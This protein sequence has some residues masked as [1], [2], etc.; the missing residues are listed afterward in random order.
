MEEEIVE[1]MKN[2]YDQ[3]NQKKKK[4]EESFII[5]DLEK[6]KIREKLNQLIEFYQTKEGK[7]LIEKYQNNFKIVVSY[8]NDLIN[9]FCFIEDY[10]I[11]RTFVDN[12]STY[13]IK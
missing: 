9:M 8:L 12:N 10:A 2:L 5:S 13:I 7:E 1:H 4:C 3:C 11:V 6:Q